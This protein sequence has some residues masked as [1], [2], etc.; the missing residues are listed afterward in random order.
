MPTLD[1]PEVDVLGRADHRH[2]G[3]PGTA[4]RQP[5]VDR[6]HHVTDANAIL[7]VLFNR[8][9]EPQIGPAIAFSFNVPSR[10][11]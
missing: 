5:P 3:R 1:R 6:R 8:L 2:R 7:R 4:R 10:R 11:A 9:G